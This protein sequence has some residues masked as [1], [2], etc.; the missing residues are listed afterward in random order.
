V[1]IF[2]VQLLEND[3]ISDKTYIEQTFES[4]LKKTENLTA[5][6]TAISSGNLLSSID[7]MKTVLKIATQS[8]ASVP[9]KVRLPIN[10]M[11]RIL[12]FSEVEHFF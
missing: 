7:I 4:S 10:T 5:T 2:Q 8:N 1:P 3:G 9:E 11:L 12:Y 6:K